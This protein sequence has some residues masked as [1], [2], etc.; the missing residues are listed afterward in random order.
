MKKEKI[1]TLLN[2]DASV[3][4]QDTV[5]WHYCCDCGLAHLLLVEDVKKGKCVVR[6]YRDDRETKKARKRMKKK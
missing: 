4:V 3:Y 5:R 6:W 2:G 1:I